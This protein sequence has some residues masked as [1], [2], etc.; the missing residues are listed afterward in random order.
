MPYISEQYR[1]NT[2]GNKIRSSIIQ[3]PLIDTQDRKIDLAPWPKEINEKGIVKFVEN[4]RPEAEMMRKVVCKPDVMILATGYTQAFD[5]LDETYP[6]PQE[7]TIRSVWKE[8]DES[9]G[10][11]GFVRPS[12]GTSS[13][14]YTL[15]T[16][17][18]ISPF[19]P[20]DTE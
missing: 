5:F 14:P 16:L 4:G 15:S 8:N 11:I 12:F 18:N 3:V 1:K 19:A 13:L 9:V 10:F 17:S 7:A 2:L 6:T 20:T